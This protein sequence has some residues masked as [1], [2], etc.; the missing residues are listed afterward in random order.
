MS[1]NVKEMLDDFV[2][3]LEFSVS[4]LNVLLNALNTP[5][6]TPTTTFSYFVN[7]IQNQ[8]GPQVQK[9]KADLETVAKA[10]AKAQEENENE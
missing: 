9:V 6:Q 7:V 3:N 2:V 4:D 8:A 5:Y 10:Q 1:E